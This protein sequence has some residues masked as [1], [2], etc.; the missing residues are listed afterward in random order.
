VGGALL[1]AWRLPDVLREPVEHHHDPKNS[2]RFGAETAMVHVADIT[3]HGMLMSGGGEPYVPPISD[4]AWLRIDGAALV[5]PSTFSE[6][7]IQ[8]TA[9]VQAIL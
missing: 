5:S 3:A 2:P 8:F 7:D 9:A 1:K 6:I 4:T